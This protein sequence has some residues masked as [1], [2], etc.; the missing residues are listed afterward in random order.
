MHSES[1]MFRRRGMALATAIAG[2]AVAAGFSFSAMAQTTNGLAAKSPKKAELD[3][4][5]EKIKRTPP[6]EQG[7][8]RS[9]YP[10]LTWKQVDCGP[11]PTYRAPQSARVR[12]QRGVALSGLATTPNLS[13]IKGGLVAGNGN[14]YIVKTT[15]KFKSVVA[16]FPAVSGVTSEANQN[17]KNEYTLQLNTNQGTSQAACAGFAYAACT[18]WSQFVYGAHYVGNNG[19]PDNSGIFIQSWVYPSQR[20]YDA[21]GCPANWEDATGETIIPSCMINSPATSVPLVPATT[22]SFASLKLEATASA[23]GNDTITL[24]VGTDVYAATQPD[25]FSNISAWWNSGEFN[26]FGDGQG[27]QATFNN[28]SSITVKLAVDDGTTNTPICGG[29]TITG[30]D[31]ATAETNNLNLF[32]CRAIAGSSTTPPTYKPSIQFTEALGQLLDN[33][34][35][36]STLLPWTETSTNSKGVTDCSNGCTGLTSH[37]GTGFAKLNGYGSAYSDTLSQNVKIPTG[38]TTPTLQYWLHITTAE[39]T[40]NSKNDTLALALYDSSG[41]LLTTLAT[42]SNLDANSGYFAYSHDLSA[43]IGQTVTIKFTGT[44]NG[45]LQTTFLLDD[46]TLT[47]GAAPTGTGIPTVGFTSTTNGLTATFTDKST[48]AAKQT[49]S[50]R[51]WTFGDGT[52]SIATNPSHTYPK[53]GT[54]RVTETVTDSDGQTSFNT[55][56]ITPSGTATTPIPTPTPTP[57]PTPKPTPTPPATSCNFFWNGICWF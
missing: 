21:K 43:Y 10:S 7:C 15:S 14:D 27:A 25:S 30:A 33:P 13:E 50:S 19:L 5:H 23:G 34:G 38:S 3:A 6:P 18:V 55:K 29:P 57:K 48:A 56:S 2:L 28:G 36:E 41:N 31:G 32:P 52:T 51:A 22:A 54:Y 39:T 42:Y 49:I 53:A 9:S 35:F 8:F 47:T 11:E 46:A 16:S 40:N 20:D 1:V 26:I 45:T 12:S 44:E 17:G 4:W 24:T 37:T